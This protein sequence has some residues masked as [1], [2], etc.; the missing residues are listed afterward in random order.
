MKKV[1]VSM[2]MV[3]LLVS[4]SLAATKAKKSA[5]VVIEETPVVSAV[6]SASKFVVSPKVGFGGGFGSAINLGC[7]V[8]MPIMPS[9]DGMGELTFYSGSG[10]SMICISGNGI[11][12]FP[13]MPGMPGNLY[14]GG[15]LVY[16]SASALGVS[17]SGIGFQALGGMNIPVPGAGNAFAQLKYLVLNFSL[18]GFSASGGGFVVEGGYRLAL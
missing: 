2:I 10:V 6:P 4:V 1:L 9:V 12:N 14:S 16:G 3:S 13:P 17:L 7:E 15:G 5:P 8:S 11:Y 18:G